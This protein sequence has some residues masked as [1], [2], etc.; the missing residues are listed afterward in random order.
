MKTAVFRRQ[1]NEIQNS[2]Q[3]AL[4]G[5]YTFSKQNKKYKILTNNTTSKFRNITRNVFIKAKCLKILFQI[6][7]RTHHHLQTHEKHLADLQCDS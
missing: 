1:L 4:I 7:I 6:Q 3:E 5:Q 2:I